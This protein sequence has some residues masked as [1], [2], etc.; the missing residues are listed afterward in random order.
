M[1]PRRFIT[2]VAGPRLAAAELA[3]L[4]E[5]VPWGLIL[6]QRNVQTRDQ[7]RQLIGSFREA[8]GRAD[9][10]VLVDQE[11]GRVQ[12][13]KPPHWR[14]HPAAATFGKL[15]D[16][17]PAAGVAAAQ[18]GA[19]LLAAELVEVGISIDC[20][21]VADVPIPGSD[22]IIGDRAFGQTAAKVAALA[23]AFASGLVEGGIVPVLKH[24]PGHGRAAVD[25]HM[26]LPEVGTERPILETSDFAAFRALADLPIAMTA[27]VV[28]SRI[29][30][31]APA[32]IS[33]TIVNEVIRGF[34]GFQGLLMSDDISM[35]ALSGTVR[36]RVGAAFT[37]GCDVVLHCNG[38][39]DEMEKVAQEA[40]ELTGDSARRAGAAQAVCRSPESVDADVDWA[41]LS[42]L[43]SRLC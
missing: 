22:P 26:R 23:G 13:L 32:T 33:A 35:G 19:R 27:H 20:A 3:F 39:L 1:H 4:R 28:F 21:P 31:F 5:A 14:A 36:Q 12:R 17:E 24:I 10:P 43:L 40:P 9:A 8:V 2:G 16:L 29:D 41:Q 42:D 7:L 25:S 38:H 15:Y 30:P 6:F 18:L 37:A 11:G 34:I